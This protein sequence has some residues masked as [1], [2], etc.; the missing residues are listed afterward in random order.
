[1]CVC[2]LIWLLSAHLFGEFPLHPPYICLLRWSQCP[3]E[4]WLCSSSPRPPGGPWQNGGEGGPSEVQADRRCCLFLSLSEH[5]SSWSKSWEFASGRQSEY[6][7]SRWGACWGCDIRT[8]ELFLQDSW[9]KGL[10]VCIHSE[11]SIMKIKGF[12]VCGLK[13][14]K[15]PKYTY[16][17]CWE[18]RRKWFVIKVLFW[19]TSPF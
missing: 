14:D 7:N 2:F 5:S 9:S 1:M 10:S 4:N 17:I 12:C 3:L 11:R 19:L 6:Q 18:E 13:T 8:K 16:V 15:F